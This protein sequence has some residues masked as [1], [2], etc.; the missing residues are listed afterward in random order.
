MNESDFLF[1]SVGKS[2]LE[3]FLG[4]MITEKTLKVP[5]FFFWVEPYLCAGHM[6]YL[7]PNDDVQYYDF[8]E[9][10]YFKQNLIDNEEYTIGN[11]KINLREAG[12]QTSYTPYSAQSVMHYLSLM[13]PLVAEIINKKKKRN[14]F[15]CSWIG[16]KSILEKHSLKT[17]ERMLKHEEGELVFY[18]GE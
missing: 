5:T 11:E 6:I 16:N 2:N 12:C 17:S 8:F 18:D 10:G 15:A 3:E 1:V 4:L 9:Q 13:Y 7:D 14:T